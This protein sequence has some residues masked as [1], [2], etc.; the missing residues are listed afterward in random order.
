MGNTMI[1][2]T[3]SIYGLSEGSI[4][5]L[6]MRYPDNIR[7]IYMLG[8]KELVIKYELSSGMNEAVF[9]SKITLSGNYYF[10]N[11]SICS[12]PCSDS[13]ITNKTTTQPGSHQLRFESKAH[14]VLI[15]QAK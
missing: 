6:D 13:T 12:P 4:I 3:E 1:T 9:F 7:D 2:N 10:N 14:Y 15:S 5:T 11:R 8:G